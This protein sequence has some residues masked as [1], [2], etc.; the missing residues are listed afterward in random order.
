[1]DM[2]RLRTINLVLATALAGAALPSQAALLLGIGE[3]GGS[4][5]LSGLTGTL[6]NGLKANILGGMGSGFAWAGG[7]TF[8]A[9]PDRGPN[10]TAW[11]SAVD[12]T[13]SYIS[14]FHTLNLSLQS[15]TKAG[16]LPFQV[17]AKLASTTLLW[18]ADKLNYGTAGTPN[19]AGLSNSSGRNYFTGRSDAFDASKGSNN[20]NN[21]RFDPEGV[22]VS[23]DG[24]SVFVSDEYGPYVYQFDR[25]TGERIKAFELPA[26]LAVKTLGST[27]AAEDKPVNTSGRVANKGMEG[28]AITPDGKMLVGIMQAPLLQDNKGQVRIVTIDV[29]TGETKQFAYKL[30]DGSGV[31]EIVAI[32]DH[33]FLI[34]ERD[35]KGLGDG[36]AAGVKKGYRIDISGATPIPNDSIKG[37]LSKY[38]VSKTQ[39][40][41]VDVVA[42]LTKPT[43]EGGAGLTAAQVPAKIEGYAFGQDVTFEGKTLHTLWVAN[44]NDF[45]SGVAGQNKFYVFGLTDSELGG[46]FVPQAITAPVPEP[47]TY[48]LMGMGLLGLCVARRRKTQR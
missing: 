26:S 25:A 34:D 9:T 6:E 21:A 45:V 19:T 39:T 30:T 29:A 12:D 33:E 11:N 18:S 16:E 28:L 7:N 8:I 32:N 37:D 20:S 41:T 10:A 36:S 2:F 1:M 38:L 46:H 4:A 15:N 23:N 47:E 27:T 17:N 5:D 24:K 13:S 44:D 40:S 3:I 35:G 42:M 43:S 14:R 31:S 48:A 22:R